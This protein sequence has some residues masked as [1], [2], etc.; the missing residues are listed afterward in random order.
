MGLDWRRN[1]QYQALVRA[2]TEDVLIFSSTL[3]PTKSSHLSKIHLK[4]STETS[5]RGR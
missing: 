4:S 3:I 1:K 2:R 5:P